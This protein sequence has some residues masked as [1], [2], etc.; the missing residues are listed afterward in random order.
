[1]EL[2]SGAC[3]FEL[4]AKTPYFES[5]RR[6]LRPASDVQAFKCI[7]GVNHEISP[8]GVGPPG[9]KSALSAEKEKRI[10]PGAGPA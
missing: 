1:M 8:G 4:L 3:R 2:H 7:Q 9:L 10:N 5:A 6:R